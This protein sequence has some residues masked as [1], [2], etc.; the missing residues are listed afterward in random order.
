MTH[1]AGLKDLVQPES[2]NCFLFRRFLLQ[3]TSS[4]TH[5]VRVSSRGYKDIWKMKESVEE[6]LMRWKDVIKYVTNCDM[7]I[8]YSCLY[9]VLDWALKDRV[10]AICL[11][12]LPQEERTMLT[13][14]YRI[15][16]R[17]HHS[18]PI[19]LNL[20]IQIRSDI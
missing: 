14:L 19:S 3:M 11:L 18:T 9:T 16:W 7:E 2:R 6:L 20:T 17:A 1:G 8:D 4:S 13:E 5:V 12:K 10:N 15:L